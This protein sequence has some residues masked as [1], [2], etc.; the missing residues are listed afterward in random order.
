MHCRIACER[1]VVQ[2]LKPTDEH[3]AALPRPSDHPRSMFATSQPLENTFFGTTDFA[4]TVKRFRL[5]QCVAVPP[6]R[7][8]RDDTGAERPKMLERRH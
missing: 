2:M 8:N 7:N 1:D 5:A 6:L 4:L 3:P